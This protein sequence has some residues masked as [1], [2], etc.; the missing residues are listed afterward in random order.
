MKYII[1]ALNVA[2]TFD[3]KD[4]LK[5]VTMRVKE[6]EV[7]SLIGASGSGKTTFLRCLNLLTEPSDGRI[8]FLGEDL[9]NPK[10]NIDKLRLNIGMVF[11]N[12][13]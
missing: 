11:Q 1:E 12:F 5:D 9:T 2:K 8:L 6:G 4:V 3:G 13:N 10:T 7:I